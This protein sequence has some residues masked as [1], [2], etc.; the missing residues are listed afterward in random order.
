MRSVIRTEPIRLTEHP[1]DDR[2]PAWSPDGRELAFA[3]RR[4]GNWELYMM[5]YDGHNQ[6]RLTFNTSDDYMPA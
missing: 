2:W 3:S 5:D 6:T 4:D 1:A